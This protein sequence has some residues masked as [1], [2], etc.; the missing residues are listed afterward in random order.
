M[1]E[2]VGRSTDFKG[3]IRSKALIFFD[4]EMRIEFF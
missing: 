1:D 3:G 2:N 4:N